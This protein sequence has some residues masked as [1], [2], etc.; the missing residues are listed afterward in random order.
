MKI[1]IK[2]V[3]KKL[4]GVYLNLI[5][6]PPLTTSNFSLE[7]PQYDFSARFLADYCRRLSVDKFEF[8]P[9][10]G[11][12]ILVYERPEYLESTLRTLL[13]SD[14]TQFEFTLYLIDDGSRNPRVRSILD[15]YKNLESEIEIKVVFQPKGIPCAG[16]SINRALTLMISDKQFD[17]LGFSDPDVIYSHNWLSKS[18][19][20]FLW[21]DTNHNKHDVVL[22][23]PYN[24]QSASYHRWLGMY[25]SEAGQFVVKKQMGLASVLLRPSAILRIGFFEEKPSDEELM[26]IRMEG[27][28]VFCAT[29]V[30]S[31]VEHIGQNSTLNIFRT[32]EVYRADFSWKLCPED[33]KNELDE[34]P[35]P[36]V[37][38]DLSAPNSINDL[39]RADKIDVAILVAEKDIE[40]FSLC[41][42]SLR[43]HSLNPIQDVFVIAAPNAS[44]IEMCKTYDL[45]F[46]N[47]QRFA[48]PEITYTDYATDQSRYK[49]LRQQFMKL[50]LNELG[51][52]DLILALDADQVFINDH[53][54]AID[55]VIS[56]PAVV[57][58]HEPYFQTYQ[59]L[60]DAP[61][62]YI[63]NIA[64]FMVF[65][66][67]HLTEMKNTIEASHNLL[68]IEAIFA[69]MD[70][71]ESSSFSEFETYGH[72]A[73][74]NHPDSYRLEFF[75][76]LEVP[77]HFVENHSQLSIEYSGIY[78]S[79]TYPHW[80]TH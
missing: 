75:E 50:S 1:Y 55:G 27:L 16:A 23:S 35:N 68:W 37:I 47:E 4:L 62:N 13:N 38:R 73:I 21:I 64:H 58:F 18:L 44:L 29:P 12:A 77:R 26:S 67:R 6:N 46:V 22:Y 34:Y 42:E 10:I 48:F 9:R 76:Y 71:S 33:W 43:K 36:S 45:E 56:I 24:S 66:K 51:K 61:P 32:T 40:T 20:Q 7:L 49:W 63:S 70:F 31:L 14:L 54:F 39:S 41:I 78:E 80:K 72:W 74:T 8:K 28:N 60:F 57:T 19:K 2:G 69:N 15:H 79:I 5:K 52:Q 30:H 3:L 59:R 25:D 11:Y 53:V 17:F 65:N